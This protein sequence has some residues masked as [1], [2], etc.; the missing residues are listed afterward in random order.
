MAGNRTRASRVAG[1]NSTTEPPMLT[2]KSNGSSR[3]HEILH[4][5]HSQL[6]PTH[7]TVCTLPLVTPVH[8]FSDLHFWFLY[9]LCWRS[10]FHHIGLSRHVCLS[11]TWPRERNSTL[12]VSIG[13][14]VVEFSPATREARVRFPANAA[15]FLLSV[16][17]RQ[18]K[19]YHFTEANLYLANFNCFYD[20]LF[21]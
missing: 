9:S 20:S 21:I 14:S 7:S 10:C 16:H 18:N 12:H 3:G 8:P 15:V 1:E 6:H 17:S 5:P 2:W 11:P 4:S 13:G 19:T